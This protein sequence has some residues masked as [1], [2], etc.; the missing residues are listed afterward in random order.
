MD[1][2]IL[3]VGSINMDLVVKAPNIPAPGENVFGTDFQTIPGGKGAN[4]A[5]GVARLGCRAR[6]A[7]RVG[8]DAFG[9]TLLAGLHQAGVNTSCVERDEQTRTGIA[10]I[11]VEDTGENSIVIATGANGRFSRESASRLTDAIAT[12]DLVLLQLELPLDP[13]AEVIAMARGLGKP[14]VLDAGPPCAYPHPQ[15][16][17]VTVLTPNEAEAG[18]M[19]GL[20]ITDMAS[21]REAAR[22]L[23]HKGAEA[24]VL[25]L[26]EN[27]AMLVD[28]C[29]EEHF[30]AHPVNVVD[31]TA[32]GDAFSAALCVVMVEGKPLEEAV[33]FAN[34]A[35]ALAVTKFGAQP[36]LPLRGE[37]EDFISKP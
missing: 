12:A 10:L 1:R 26:G 32:A 3:I 30:P 11:T 24:V 9:D 21:A 23:L 6:M 34:A 15:F 2:T 13:V 28:G 31:T 37:L 19:S 4:Q 8:V 5:V 16:F 29:R 33:R 18:A 35:G 36:S 7:G 27:G 14:V 17:N 22:R 25:K 20:E